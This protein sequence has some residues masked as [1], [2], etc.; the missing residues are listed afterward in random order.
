MV[1]SLNSGRSLGAALV[2]LM[3]ISCATDLW[4][5]P[6]ASRPAPRTGRTDLPF[7][8][9]QEPLP[10]AILARLNGQEISLDRYKEYLFTKTQLDQFMNLVDAM[11]LDERSKELGVEV[12]AE[13]LDALVEN[14]IQASIE[15]I[16]KGD[17]AAFEL[18][19]NRR[20]RTMESHRSWQRQQ[21]RSRLQLE[22]CIL[23]T[24]QVSPDDVAKEFAKLYG[25][26]GV[27]LQVNHILLRRNRSGETRDLESEANKLL[28]RLEQDPKLFAELVKEHSDDP[29][30]KRNGGFIANYRPELFGAEFHRTVE[31]LSELELGGPVNSGFGVHIVQLVKRTVTTFDEVQGEIEQELQRRVPT[32]TEKAV[33]RSELRANAKIEM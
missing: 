29:M 15:K 7:E 26:G 31:S 22:R 2:A 25:P 3:L 5:Q 10:A 4:S 6:A 8:K 32:S 16:H 21:F 20:F 17:R 9:V 27:H 14:N 24:R 19:L 13:E 28:E 23:K 1:A 33:F 11:L 18:A 12:T 30:T